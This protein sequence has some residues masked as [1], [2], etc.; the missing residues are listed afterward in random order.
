MMDQSLAGE[1]RLV[2]RMAGDT[3]GPVELSV[4]SLEHAI[5]AI[6]RDISVQGIGLVT[7][8]FLAAGTRLTIKRSDPGHGLAPPLTAEVRQSTKL[9]EE[10]WLLG[11]GFS[12]LLSADDILK[13]G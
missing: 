10:T 8:S 1:R 7:T 11:C 5:P 2:R 6:V 13:L 12:R 9:K 4:D 3:I